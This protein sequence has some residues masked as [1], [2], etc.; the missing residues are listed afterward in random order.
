M[1]TRSEQMP[2]LWRS[3]Y[4]DFGQAKKVHNDLEDETVTADA[5]YTDEVLA[6]IAGQGFNGIWVHGLLRHVVRLSANPGFFKYLL[7]DIYLLIG[8]AKGLELH[9]ATRPG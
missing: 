3:P 2:S 8:G 7:L 6:D 4:S 1:T 5:V 9:I